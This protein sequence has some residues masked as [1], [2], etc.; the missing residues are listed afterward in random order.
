MSTN[1]INIV[2]SSSDEYSVH[3]GT[4][5]ISILKNSLPEETFHF[6]IIESGISEK[7]KKNLRQL[8]KIR[9]FDIDFLKIDSEFF[10]KPCY[11]KKYEDIP[12]ITT[13]TF[14]KYLIP[15]LLKCIDKVL[16]LDIDT[17]VLGSISEFYNIDLGD[18]Y[19]AAV[20]DACYNCENLMQLIRQ[21]ID[22]ENYF[23]AGVILFNLKK[24]REDNITSKLLE[25]HIKLFNE[26]RIIFADQCVLNY[27]FN[28]K[29]I[30]SNLKY[31]VGFKWMNVDEEYIKA[32]Q[33]PV[34][35][36]FTTYRK[37]WIFNFKH[38]FAKEYF[39]YLRYSSFQEA[40]RLLILY[41]LHPLGWIFSIKKDY[42]RL[43][44]RFLGIKISKKLN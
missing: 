7:H 19:V 4:L 40:R 1:V 18:N 2:M 37:P 8:T 34:I 36:H 33:K 24:C 27:T 38:P 31:N 44:I 35:V 42:T 32:L 43:T 17:L 12:Q 5:I 21:N 41:Y 16:Y 13:Q 29:T 30:L 15:D 39:K 22:V 9:P 14:Y 6:Y 10:N 26:N 11:T 3:C 25:T 28:N 23:N 20:L